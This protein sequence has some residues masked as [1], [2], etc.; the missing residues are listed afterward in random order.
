MYKA[1]WATKQCYKEVIRVVER[2]VLS[3]RL[4]YTV[5]TYVHMCK[6]LLVVAPFLLAMQLTQVNLDLFISGAQVIN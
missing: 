4:L 3:C 1:G 5:A 6:I 2:L